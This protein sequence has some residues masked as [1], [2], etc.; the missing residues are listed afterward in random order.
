MSF[1]IVIPVGP[2]DASIIKQQIAYTQK[3]I[4]DYRNIY[5]ICYD[6]SIIIDGSITINENIFPFNIDTVTEHHGKLKRN[7]WYLQQLLK[8]YVGKIIPNILDKYLVIDSDT[9]S[10][11]PTTFVENNKCLY[12]YGA[13]YHTSYFDHMKK[14]HPDL[15]K[16]NENMSGICHHMIFETKILDELMSKIEKF[17]NNTF[18]NIFLKLVTPKDINV[19][20]ASEYELYFNYM[21]KFNFDKIKIRKLN[22][23]NTN[24]L[25]TNNNLDYISYHWYSRKK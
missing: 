21:L 10:L 5:L 23:K 2:N 4:I 13:G 8:L 18:F 15:V 12:N 11:K 22:W 16:M 24:T 9:F 1:D 14:L 20:G 17:H 19:G 25:D 3:N 7:E 6:P